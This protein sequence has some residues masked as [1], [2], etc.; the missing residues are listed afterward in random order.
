MTGQLAE[1]RDRLR[2]HDYDS[3]AADHA[4]AVMHNIRNALTPIN[5]IAADLARQESAGWKSNL[6]SALVELRRPHLR[7]RSGPPS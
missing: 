5:A 6:A 1:L 3:G 4:S 2:K 7:R